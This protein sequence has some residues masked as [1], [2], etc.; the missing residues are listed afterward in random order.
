MESCDC[1]YILLQCL[2][3]ICISVPPHLR[4][5]HCISFLLWT[6][7]MHSKYD[8]VT[9]CNNEGIL[10]R[11]TYHRLRISYCRRTD[12]YLKKKLAV[13]AILLYSAKDYLKPNEV[14]FL[15]LMSDLCLNMVVPNFSVISGPFWVMLSKVAH[16]WCCSGSIEAKYSGRSLLEL[17]HISPGPTES[18]GCA[19]YRI[20]E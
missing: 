16:S 15:L 1:A 3:F 5:T 13:V 6:I 17:Q 2:C 8:C 11:L 7:R 20:C 19:T 18:T 14:F 10:Y 9:P 12:G 4:G